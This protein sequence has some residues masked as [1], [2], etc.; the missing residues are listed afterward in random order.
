MQVDA[1][2]EQSKQSNTDPRLVTR[3]LAEYVKKQKKKPVSGKH[4]C[5]RSCEFWYDPRARNHYVCTHSGRVHVCARACAA[6]TFETSE[7]TRVCALTG[8][9]VSEYRSVASFSDYERVLPQSQYNHVEEKRQYR[10]RKMRDIFFTE[11]RGA[12]PP[13]T[14]N[15][16]LQHVLNRCIV[17]YN[18][19]CEL[20]PGMKGEIMWDHHCEKTRMTFVYALVFELSQPV[21]F[22]GKTGV[23]F[24]QNMDFSHINDLKVKHKLQI[25]KMQ[26][27]IRKA[28]QN[29]KLRHVFDTLA[30][31]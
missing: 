22:T 13:E 1:R 16:Q 2:L 6:P 11:L 8:I 30:H 15:A 10:D 12:V 19:L 23:S 17:V 25:A 18:R 5:S 29:T 14:S 4:A 20:T 3:L 7:M 28:V 9:E 27:R 24:L 21:M 31:L 26:K